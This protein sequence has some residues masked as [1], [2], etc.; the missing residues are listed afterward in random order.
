MDN[1]GRRA[2]VFAPAVLAVVLILILFY[3]VIGMGR[4]LAESGSVQPA[5][6]W[7]PTPEFTRAPSQQYPVELTL[8][9]PSMAG[10]QPLRSL[11]IQFDNPRLYDG[12]MLL[13]IRNADNS[14]SQFPL[15]GSDIRDNEYMAFPMEG[16]TPVSGTLTT[17]G[18]DSASVIGV[19]GP[20]V[21]TATCAVYELMDG[22]KLTPFGCS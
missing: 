18:G 16:K 11:A 5:E 1:M 3:L 14:T 12:S 4:A 20:D 7:M 17:F 8:W 10:Q 22:T 13:T 21:D 15:V 9:P 6:P 19:S 2:R